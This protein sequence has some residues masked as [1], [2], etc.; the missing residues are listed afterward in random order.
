M[1]HH[2]V[3]AINRACDRSCAFCSVRAADSGTAQQRGQRAGLAVRK[4]IEAGASA[5][6][7]TGGE[8]TLEPY[9]PQLLHLAKTLGVGDLT[10]ETHAGTIDSR[11]AQLLARAGLRRAVVAVNSLDV[12]TADAISGRSNDQHST[13]IGVRALLTAGIDI[14]IAVALVPQNAATLLDLRQNC[15]QL[16][17]DTAGRIVRIVVRTIGQAPQPLALLDPLAAAA[18]LAQ[19]AQQQVNHAAPPLEQAIGHELPPCAF[20]DPEQVIELFRLSEQRVARESDR[21]RRLA[22]CAE[23]PLATVCPGTPAVWAS[24]LETKAFAVHEWMV[25][26]VAAV[27][28]VQAA[29]EGATLTAT[30][31]QARW[32]AL[33]RAMSLTCVDSF[34]ATAADPSVIAHLAARRAP[35]P[36]QWPLAAGDCDREAIELQNGLRQLLRREVP[37]PDRV[38]QAVTA[39]QR[40]GLH[41]AVL[42][43]AVAGVAGQLRT[44][45]FAA[46]DRSLLA[47]A[48]RLDPLLG[49]NGSQKANAIQQFGEWFGYPLCCV[50]AFMIG[51]DRDDAVLVAERAARQSDRALSWPQN[52]AVV[53]VRLGSWLPCAPDCAQTLRQT[54]AVAALLAVHT[55]TWLAAA[56]PLLQAHVLTLGFDRTVILLA[57]EREGNHWRYQRVIGLGQLAGQVHIA[58]RLPWLAFEWAIVE[59]LRAGDA[60]TVQ[61][62]AHGSEIA[63]LRQGAQIHSLVFS[64]RAPQILDFTL[65]SPN[66]LPKIAV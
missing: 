37:D 4:A 7:I 53:P 25:A 58:R 46:G 6:T 11:Q 61:S 32:P 39:L 12:A 14:E 64:G 41:T 33:L 44:H 55:P 38:A 15:Q 48:L 27:D 9:L 60:L 21:Y 42:Q 29:D 54:T 59:K 22:A 36:Q 24:A 40:V 34:T 10:L 30:A 62:L 3:I 23:C 16:S 47:A 50:D 20:A 31:V 8:P 28:S 52:W 56:R 1:A 66:Q 63:V 35:E 51:G 65:E 26:A 2:H 19:A 49:G 45:I 43:S 17:K 5:L 18:A 57:A 13:L